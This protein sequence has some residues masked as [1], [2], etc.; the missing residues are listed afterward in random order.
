[1]EATVIITDGNNTIEN[2]NHMR[3]VFV[4][5]ITKTR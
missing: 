2:N 3:K 1:M 4:F 5:R